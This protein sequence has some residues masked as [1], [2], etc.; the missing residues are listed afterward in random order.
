MAKELMPIL[1]GIIV[2]AIIMI[3]VTI[4]MVAIDLIVDQ[5]EKIFNRWI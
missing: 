5:I 4:G 3:V 1:A 2:F